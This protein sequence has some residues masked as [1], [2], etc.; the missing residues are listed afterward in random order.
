MVVFHGCTV[1]RGWARTY[2]NLVSMEAVRGAEQYGW[3]PN[4]AANAPAH[5]T[6]L[7]FTRNVV[8]SMD[9]TPV[10]FSSY[11][12]CK[13]ATSNAYELALSVLFESGIQHFADSDSSYRSQSQP[14]KNFLR[15]VPNTWDDI[16][17]LDGYPGKLAIIARR[18]GSE[19]YVAAV[20]GE[21]IPKTLHPTISFL[22]TGTYH[23]SI[24]K[25][26]SSPD[27]IQEQNITYKTG[28][29]LS[30]NVLPNGGFVMRI[31]K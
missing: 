7:A 14:V 11:S 30:V 21:P 23:M 6:I 8:G 25:D 4:Y 27:E 15:I 22:G 19:W 20:N 24:L 18:K 26:G 3:D 12:C 16:R 5:N 31:R 10:T 9:F 17:F 13:H 1:P 29:K 2:P 28:D